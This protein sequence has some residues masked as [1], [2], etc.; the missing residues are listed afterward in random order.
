MEQTFYMHIDSLNLA[1]YFSSACLKPVKYITNRNADIQNKFEDHLLIST[2]RSAVNSDCSLEIV[3]TDSEKKQLY[4]LKND[5]FLYSKP[6]PITRVKKIY[7]TSAN[8]MDKIITVVEMGS[9]F[10][11]R[12]LVTLMPENEYQK[13][14]YSKIKNYSKGKKTDFSPEIR[15]YD[16]LLGGFALM[17]T[18][19]ASPMNYPVSYFSTLARFNSVIAK[20]LDQTNHKV[21]KKFWDAF[22]GKNSFKN[23]YPYLNRKITKEDLEEVARQEQ[24]EVRE[25]PISGIIDFNSLQQASYIIAVLYNYGLA[26]EGRRNKVDGLIIS[27][28]RQDIRP[29]RSEVV[30]LCYGLNRGHSAFNNK[31]QSVTVKFRLDSQV[32][33]YTIESLYQYAFYNIEQSSTFPYLD[34]WCPK[35]SYANIIPAQGYRMFDKVIIDKP[36]AESKIEI[37]EKVQESN[38]KEKAKKTFLSQSENELEKLCSEI[39][40]HLREEYQA[41][42]A[43]KE[44]TIKELESKLKQQ[45]KINEELL[46]RNAS[47]QQQN[48]ISDNNSYVLQDNTTIYNTAADSNSRNEIDYKTAFNEARDIIVYAEKQ[49]TSKK[50]KP[51]FLEFI[52]KYINKKLF[53]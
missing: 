17:N 23:L 3:L 26:D 44:N 28:F 12:Q 34:M 40:S 5:A 1:H 38:R 53:P 19:A 10:I 7:F 9:G 14:D 37:K 33:Y 30:A 36:I 43:Q 46:M 49:I 16:S 8:T 18:V 51:I 15:K 29:E 45:Q 25:N 27:H 21:D 32:D 20:N 48:R 35:Q 22:E 11:P 6:L 4:N 50:V 13:I 24:Q 2:K 41:K 52:N 39:E 31:Y 47:L 42:M